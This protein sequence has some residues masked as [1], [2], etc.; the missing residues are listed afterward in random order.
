MRSA[1]AYH[2][3]VWAHPN[4]MEKTF[5]GGSKTVKFVNIFSLVSFALYGTLIYINHHN[6]ID[7]LHI[8]DI[9]PLSVSSKTCLHSFAVTGVLD[10]I[11]GLQLI[12]ISHG[13]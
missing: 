7:R 1:K 2:R 6:R 13:W 4:F 11:A 5:A 10:S 12:S 9:V 8:H 3:L